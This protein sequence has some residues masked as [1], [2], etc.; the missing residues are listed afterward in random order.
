M[1]KETKDVY[2]F[3]LSEDVFCSEEVYKFLL[4]FIGSRISAT[5]IEIKSK[6]IEENLD[7][8]PSEYYTTVKEN[9]SKEIIHLIKTNRNFQKNY[10]LTV[11][12]H[13]GNTYV[14]KQS[15]FEK[16]LFWRFKTY[17]N[18]LGTY[19]VMNRGLMIR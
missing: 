13:N 1:R 9:T 4:G 5:C 7:D 2:K 14:F 3:E 8:T 11:L 15:E 10:C 16:K 6:L 19:Q 12:K 18:N 17:F